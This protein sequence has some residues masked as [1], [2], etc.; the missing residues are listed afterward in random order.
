[1]GTKVELFIPE[2]GEGRLVGGRG[3]GLFAGRH[4]AADLGPDPVCAREPGRPTLVE[5]GSHD[6][7]P[8]AEHGPHTLYPVRDLDLVCPQSITLNTTRK[9]SSTLVPTFC[10]PTSKRPTRRWNRCPTNTSDCSSPG[11]PASSSP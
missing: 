3:Q 2:R 6:V 4:I 7:G 10:I 11:E 8:V 1:M 5:L 9:A